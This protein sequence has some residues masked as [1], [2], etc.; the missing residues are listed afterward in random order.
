LRSKLKVL[1]YRFSPLIE[2][3]LNDALRPIELADISE[4]LQYIELKIACKRKVEELRAGR[5]I[6]DLG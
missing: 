5:E 1:E 4:Y 2:Q 3:M 6:V